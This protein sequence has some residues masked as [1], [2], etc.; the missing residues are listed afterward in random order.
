MSLAGKIVFVTGAS[1]GIG[2]KIAELFSRSGATVF[3]TSFSG[4]QKS[5]VCS[6]L[7]KADFADVS[8]ILRISEEITTLKPDILINNAGIN[9]IDR[10]EDINYEDF[11]KIYNINTL[12]PF[13]FCQAAVGHMKQQQWGRI[14]NVASIWSKV[15][16][17]KRASYSASKFALDG[18]TVSLALEHGQDGILAN[19]VSPG[20]VDTDL[21]RKILGESGVSELLKKVPMGRLACPE[22]IAELVLW[23]SS[24]QNTFL[25]AQ[26]ISIDG[27]FTR[28]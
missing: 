26:N 19:C 6:K 25:T 27:G 9:K 3:G 7:I 10:F 17:E 12:A 13:V 14:V 15:S 28:G 1:S 4:S 5:T 23:L 18:L 11:Q 2:E 21:T 20:F 24:E 16:I 8:Q 22:E